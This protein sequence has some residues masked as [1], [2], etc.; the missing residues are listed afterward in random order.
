M[1]TVP[2]TGVV[3]FSDLKAIFGGTNPIRLSNYYANAS[4]GF[5]TG[6]TGIPNIGTK[7]S[8]NLFKGKAKG[9]SGNGLYNFTSHTFTNAGATGRNGP[10]ISQCRSAYST[11]TWAQDTTN[12]YLNMS[13]QGYQLW[14]VP[15]TGQY[16]IRA[17]GGG[18][19]NDQNGLQ[20]YDGAVMEGTVTLTQG[21][22]IVIVVG[23]RGLDSPGP[24]SFS[25]AGGGGGG[26]FVYKQSS[27][28][29]LLASGGGGGHY[30]LARDTSIGNGKTSN[31]TTYGGSNGYGGSVNVS[32][33]GGWLSAGSSFASG[34]G[35]LGLTA[36]GG[37]NLGSAIGS[38]DPAAGGFGGGAGNYNNTVGGAGG[39]SGGGRTASTV[40]AQ[41]IGEGGGSYF[42]SEVTNRKTSDGLYNGSG[43]TSLGI[44][45]RDQGYVQVEALF[46]I[47]L[48]GGNGLYNFSSHTFT[49]ASAT[50]PNGPALS[51]C[52]TGYSS[53]SWAQDTTNN[54]LNMVNNGVQLWKVPATGSY[55]FVVTGAH[56]AMG[57]TSTT[58]SRGGRGAIITGTFNLSQG[59][60]LRMI[61]GQGGSYDANNGGGGGASVVYNETTGALL[62]VAGGGGGTRQAASVNGTDASLNQ[63]GFTPTTSG[64]ND[65]TTYNNTTYTYNGKTA[66]TGY[67]GVEGN[68]SGY[69]DSG[70]GWLGNGADDASPASSVATS[71]NSTA[72]GGG[73]GQ[74]GAGGFGGGGSGA[75]SNGGG[76]GGGY[77]GGNGGWIAGGGGS[78]YNPSA[79]SVSTAIDTAR[80]YV[81]NGSP[82]HGSIQ[83]TANFSISTT[84]GGSLTS[85]SAITAT[86]AKAFSYIAIPGAP[87]TL[88]N[89][90]QSFG[91]TSTSSNDGT[92][93]WVTS[94]SGNITYADSPIA[95]I[96]YFTNYNRVRVIDGDST[97]DG[98]DWSVFN[99]GIANGSSDFDGTNATNAY[100][101]GENTYSGGTGGQAITVGYVWGFSTSSGWTL[102]YQIPLPGTSTY[103]HSNGSW[104]TSGGTVSSGDGKRAE[105][106][107]LQ[108]THLGFS[109]T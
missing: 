84:G 33:G 1:S 62:F 99:F 93:S 42:A 92:G 109:V 59:D 89:Y 101:G 21:D 75:G 61:V 54:Y 5:T 57:T 88:L 64:T 87:R 12:N 36:V 46:T 14:K 63:W 96:N 29:L 40:N 81:L 11:A 47:T 2:S 70:A 28:T 19:G 50:G 79:T 13:T 67:G 45:N 68:P 49:N 82:V 85:I 71:L 53:A 80:S 94:Y 106:D 4:S 6:V 39:Y 56:G 52:R 69:G 23:Q 78:Y 26:S 27:N 41:S 102:L 60:I 83:V 86:S 20:G 38:P 105:F 77:T 91:V 73:V 43:V 74:G 18:G 58:G 98:P 37:Y 34:D 3:K 32:N 97:A 31:N 16:R 55:T 72:V 8:I 35:I 24:V 22:I 100:F 17:A 104:F 90:L 76:G 65:S 15:A 103:N 30:D 10:V 9:G 51:Q 7:I 108:I 44:T 25:R 107:S 95:T 66:S 48:G